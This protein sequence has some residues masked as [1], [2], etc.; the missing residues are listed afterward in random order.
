MKG[1]G[2][3]TYGSY[4]AKVNMSLNS[5]RGSNDGITY[6]S[7]DESNFKKKILK[8]TTPPGEVSGIMWGD[9]IIRGV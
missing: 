1:R 9:R 7:F 6:I 5:A 4:E 8:F 2:Y 3:T